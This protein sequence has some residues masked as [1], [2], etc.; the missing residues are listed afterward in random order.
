MNSEE[1]LIE[2]VA[3]GDRSHSESIKSISTKKVKESIQRV[4]NLVQQLA[5]E[6]TVN[7]ADGLA[8]DEVEI[9][10][11]LTPAGE[12]VLLG[13]GQSNGAITLRFRRSSKFPAVAIAGSP[14]LTASTGGTNLSKLQALLA[15]GKWQEANQETWNVICQAANKNVGSVLSAEEIKQIPCEVLQAIDSLWKQHSQGRYGFSSQNQIYMSSI[16]G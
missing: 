5:N 7:Q 10:I 1:I 4:A 6:S 2:F 13:D 8:L 9:A 15:N 11:K 16:L 12:A 14:P 3:N